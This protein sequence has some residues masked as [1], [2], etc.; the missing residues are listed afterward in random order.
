MF[1]I[2][3]HLFLFLSQLALAAL[4]CSCFKK[5]KTLLVFV[6]V[7]FFFFPIAFICFF[8]PTMMWLYLSRLKTTSLFLIS[9]FS[10]SSYFTNFLRTL[11]FIDEQIWY[12]DFQNQWESFYVYNWIWLFLWVLIYVLS[13]FKLYIISFVFENIHQLVFVRKVFKA[14]CFNCCISL[15][16]TSYHFHGLPFQPFKIQVL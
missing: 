11:L 10:F 14:Y 8:L 5:V 12:R 1:L 15:S 4:I 3:L 2:N 13:S 16:I 7:F 6:L 9:W